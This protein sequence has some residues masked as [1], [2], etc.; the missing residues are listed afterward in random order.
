M[1]RGHRQ[2][3]DKEPLEHVLGVAILMT[4][5]GGISGADEVTLLDSEKKPIVTLVANEKH[6]GCRLIIPADSETTPED[7]NR[8]NH[9]MCAYQLIKESVEQTA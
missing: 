3:F 2:W 4:G 6:A 1:N 5:M 7:L 8:L 9:F